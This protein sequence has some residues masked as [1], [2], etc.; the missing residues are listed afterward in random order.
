MGINGKE[1]LTDARYTTP[2]V[3]MVKPE[4]N[5][6]NERVDVLIAV[7]QTVLKPWLQGV[8]PSEKGPIGSL[9]RST[10]PAL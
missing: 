1:N 6:A 9:P 5:G 2:Q 4:P 7:V 10:V 3:V 8:V